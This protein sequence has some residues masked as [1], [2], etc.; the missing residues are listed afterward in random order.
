VTKA[1]AFALPVPNFPSALLPFYEIFKFIFYIHKQTPKITLLDTMEA[2]P[3][4]PKGAIVFDLFPA[5]A[6]G[7]APPRAEI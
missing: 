5:A 3:S 6:S 1:D 7:L 2:P 4:I